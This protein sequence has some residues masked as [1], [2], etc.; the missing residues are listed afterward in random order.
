LNTSP[1]LPR[2]IRFS[3]WYRAAPV[4]GA[5]PAAVAELFSGRIDDNFTI[6]LTSALGAGLAWHFLG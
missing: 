3:S 5:V 2:P 1:K 6:P 4:A